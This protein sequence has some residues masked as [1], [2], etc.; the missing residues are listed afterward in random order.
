[1][2]FNSV[3]TFPASLLQSSHDPSEIILKY[4]FAAQETFSLLSMLKTA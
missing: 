2:Q 3:K 1:M 4:R